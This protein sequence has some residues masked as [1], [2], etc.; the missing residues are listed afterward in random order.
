MPR[1]TTS[2]QQQVAY[3]DHGGDGSPVVMLHSFL[4]DGRMFDPQVEALGGAHRCITV[5]ERG[6]GGTPADAPFD[7]WDVA[8]DVT[9]VLDELGI[10]R[11]AVVGTSQGGFVALRVAL[12]APERVTGLA[13]MGTSAAPEPEESATQYSELAAAW[14]THGP[15]DELLDVVQSVCLGDHPAGPWRDRWAAVDG[16]VLQRIMSTLVG[17]DGIEDRLGEIEVPVL[18]MHGDEDGSYPVA[19]AEEIAA[20]VPRCEQLV[21]VPGGAHFL[22][23]TD[24]DEVTPMLVRFLERLDQ[25]AAT[26]G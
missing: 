26:A 17:R 21:V 3:V 2:D 24:A 18:V 8:R 7:Y 19:R 11:A 23:L 4:M 12:L 25:R 10:E 16:A 13:V 6:H 9:A 22:S 1:V 5:D 14:A 15:S 20:A